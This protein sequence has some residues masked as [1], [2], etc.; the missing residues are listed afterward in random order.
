M[1]NPIVL[2]IITAAL[3][4]CYHIVFTPPP[5][6]GS[7]PASTSDSGTIAV[8]DATPSADSRAAMNPDSGTPTSPDSGPVDLPPPADGVDAATIEDVQTP[9]TGTLTVSL[10][11]DTPPGLTIFLDLASLP[12]AK[13][14]F[15]ADVSAEPIV[16]LTVTHRGTGPVSDLTSVRL[17]DADGRLI[18]APQEIDPSTQTVRFGGVRLPVS[19]GRFSVAVV[20]DVH[21][22]SPVGG[23]HFFAIMNPT[24]VSASGSVTIDGSYP[25]MSNG[26]TVVAPASPDSGMPAPDASVEDASVPTDDAS[27]EGCGEQPTPPAWHARAFALPIVDYRREVRADGR[28]VLSSHGGTYQTIMANDCPNAEPYGRYELYELELSAS[29]IRNLF[30]HDPFQGSQFIQEFRIVRTVTNIGD[31]DSRTNILTWYFTRTTYDELIDLTSPQNAWVLALDW[32]VPHGN[33]ELI[34]RFVSGTS[35]SSFLNEG[36]AMHFQGYGGYVDPNECRSADYRDPSGVRDFVP[37]VPLR[38]SFCPAT[39]QG[40][41]KTGQCFWRRFEARYGL[42]AIQA[43]IGRLY[44]AARITGPT[45][46]STMEQWVYANIQTAIIPVVGEGFWAEFSGFGMSPTMADG[47]VPMTT[48][49]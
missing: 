17:V 18:A 6:G 14:T 48:C 21:A 29:F 1:K 35:I 15:A 27:A 20:A 43:V 19:R 44:D 31:Y 9:V 5:T 41:Y 12:M 4:G 23:S 39:V 7:P 22:P 3:A 13:F 38:N 25:I 33:H 32:T 47:A 45:P 34:H 36:L 24:D 46:S 30:G 40:W 42:A 16:D 37:Y 49:P 8:Q 28:L 26:F 10:A 11:S 2:S